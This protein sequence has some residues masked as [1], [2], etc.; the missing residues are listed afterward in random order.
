MVENG[1][2]NQLKSLKVSRLL[3]HGAWHLASCHFHFSTIELSRKRIFYLLENAITRNLK[4]AV[5]F[6][7]QS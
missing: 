3:G 6:I 2:P 4:K 1:S 5:S 7:Y